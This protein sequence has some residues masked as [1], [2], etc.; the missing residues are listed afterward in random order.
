[1]K[2]FLRP[3]YLPVVLLLA[4]VAGFCLRLWAVG[5]GLTDGLYE[6]RPAAWLLLAVVTAAAALAALV[7]SRCL[8]KRKTYALNF[9][10]S[11]VGAA[12]A[13]LGA[14]AVTVAGLSWLRGSGDLLC[15]VTGALGVAAGISMVFSAYAR[16]TGQNAP[17]LGNLVVC[18]FF[19]AHMFVSCRSWSNDPNLLVYVFPM[20]ASL[21]VVPAAYQLTCIAADVGDRRHSLFWSALTIF[22]CAVSLTDRAD[23]FYHAAV[24]IWLATNLCSLDPAEE[25]AP[26]EEP[27]EEAVT[28]PEEQL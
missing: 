20:A 17:V 28:Q 19:S 27:A 22:F 2:K 9:P 16:L 24:L 12:G 8:P 15:T 5:S 1:M 26:G 21:C 25:E 6:R 10:P 7:L 23:R 13:M 14:V 18:L 11:K 3:Q 4:G